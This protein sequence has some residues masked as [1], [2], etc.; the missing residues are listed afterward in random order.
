M[1]SASIRISRNHQAIFWIDFDRVLCAKWWL[2][3]DVLLRKHADAL[4]EISLRALHHCLQYEAS[5][6]LDC[7]SGAENSCHFCPGFQKLAGSWSVRIDILFASLTTPLPTLQHLK[8]ELLVESTYM[9]FGKLFFRDENQDTQTW[10]FRLGICRF[11]CIRW[12]F[13][14]LGTK[15]WILRC[16]CSPVPRFMLFLLSFFGVNVFAQGF[17]PLFDGIVGGW[18]QTTGVTQGWKKANFDWIAV[19]LVVDLGCWE[20]YLLD[21]QF[22]SVQELS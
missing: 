8:V 16:S 2:L 3:Q 5:L 18:S 10:G 7:K 15:T 9:R 6:G 22:N 20:R 11:W 12:G 14:I 19:Y 13:Q 21:L 17:G 4:W 1:D